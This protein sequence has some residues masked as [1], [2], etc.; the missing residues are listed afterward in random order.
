MMNVTCE[1]N[2]YS[3]PAQSKIK[4][5]SAWNYKSTMVEL[6]VDG[7]RYQVKGRELISAI[8][9]CLISFDEE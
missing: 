8:E 4:V 2:D 3:E 7:N 9:R 5:H 1:I 6:E